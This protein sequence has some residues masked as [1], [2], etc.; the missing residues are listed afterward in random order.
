MPSFSQPNPVQ[1]LQESGEGR[2]SDRPMLPGLQEPC[3]WTDLFFKSC[4]CSPEEEPAHW[5]SACS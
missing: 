1:P 5:S 2:C 4:H 3:R